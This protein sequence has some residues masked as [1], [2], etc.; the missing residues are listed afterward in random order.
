MYIDSHCHLDAPEF[1]NE[2]AALAAEA[3]ASGVSWIVLPAVARANFSTV[4]QLAT[5]LPNCV[6]ALGIHPLFVPQATESDLQLLRETVAAAMK[7]QRFVAIGEIGLDFFVPELKLQAMR[8]KQEFF[9]AEQ[10]MIARDFDLPVILHVRRSQ[11]TLLKYLRRFPVQGGIAHAFNGSQQQAEMFIQLGF[12]LGFGGAMTFTRALQIRR[13]AASLPAT[14][15]VLETDSPDIS[16]A[17]LH[18]ARNTPAQIPHIAAVLAELRGQPL[19]L[20][21]EQTTSNVAR[22]LP[23][24]G[25]LMMA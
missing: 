20:L 18:P 9:Y 8:E 12:A 16:P 13:L 19:A 21:A 15:I 4:A 10:L 24:L 2:P 5:N 25:S 14:A 6:Y 17:W 11:D 3:A 23:R 7:D 1:G 22:V